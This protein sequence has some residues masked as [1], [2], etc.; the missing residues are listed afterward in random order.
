MGYIMVIF[1]YSP[2]LRVSW[3]FHRSVKR[4]PVALTEGFYPVE[5]MEAEFGLNKK[6][7]LD[8][9]ARIGDRG[10]EAAQVFKLAISSMFIPGV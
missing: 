1:M 6:Y 9:H 5:A 7:S 8:F 10:E 3:S 2:C 4:K